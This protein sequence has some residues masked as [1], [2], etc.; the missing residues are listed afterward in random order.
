M[1]KG[2]VSISAVILHLFLIGVAIAM[3]WQM[4]PVVRGA[5]S[6]SDR[7]IFYV[8][9]PIYIVFVIY[10]MVAPLVNLKSVTIDDK[11][12]IY[13]YLFFKKSILLI[14]VDGFF[15][16]E[17]PSRDYTYETIYPVSNNKILPPVSSF[18]ISNYDEFK[19][20]MNLKMLGKVKFSWKNY[21]AVSIFKK[22]SE[23]S[24]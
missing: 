16:M 6:Q 2:K 20:N 13:R 9:V 22:Y 8:A 10:A 24:R 21:L 18:Y 12:V 5:E 15:T 4:A 3:Y 1:I 7:Y 19:N 17:I 11:T 23:L 14:D